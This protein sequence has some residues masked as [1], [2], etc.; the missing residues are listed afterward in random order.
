MAGHLWAGP[1]AYRLVSRCVLHQAEQVAALFQAFPRGLVSRR[2][3]DQAET[4][5]KENLDFRAALVSHD[6]EPKLSF[7]RTEP[8]TEALLLDLLAFALPPS[9]ARAPM[10]FALAF[11]APTGLLP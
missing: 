8:S 5:L 3:R 2:L 1:G 11:P 9:R 10:P 7:G 6:V 4:F